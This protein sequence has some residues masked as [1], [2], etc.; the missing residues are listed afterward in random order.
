MI[1]LHRAKHVHMSACTCWNLD[2]WVDHVN[3]NFLIVTVCYRLRVVNIGGNWMKDI[4]D[5]YILFLTTTYESTVM[6]KKKKQHKTIGGTVCGTK[7][8]PF[9]VSF[10][11]LP[12]SGSM[13]SV[14]SHHFSKADL[15]NISHTSHFSLK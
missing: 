9:G 11:D 8:K 2:R 10:K 6:S 12:C 5:L 3:A 4:L 15:F 7:D 14:F 13:P 1:K